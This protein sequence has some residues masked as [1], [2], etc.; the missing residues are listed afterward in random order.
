MF[1]LCLLLLLSGA[2]LCS[3]T[4]ILVTFGVPN[5]ARHQVGLYWTGSASTPRISSIKPWFGNSDAQELLVSVLGPSSTQSEQVVPGTSFV[6]RSADLTSRVRVTIGENKASD[7]DRPYTISF[8]NLSVE[9]R[10]G[11]FPLELQH[12]NAGFIWIDPADVVEHI[13]GQNHVFTVRDKSKSPVFSV[14]ILGPAK[15]EL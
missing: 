5:D 7:S 14:T 3:A 6:I 8:V 1:A 2:L 15:R 12:S 9:D 11:P 4:D 13:T 10:H